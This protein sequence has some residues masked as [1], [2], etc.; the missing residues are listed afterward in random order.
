[1]SMDQAAGR[2]PV[3]VSTRPRRWVRPAWLCAAAVLIGLAARTSHYA[4]AQS[5]WYD[6]AFVLLNVFERSYLS[7]LGPLDHHLISPPGYLMLLRLLYTV[8]GGGERV[9]RLPSLV[10]GVIALGVM[11]PLGRR[12]AG[13]TGRF[14][15]V[16]LAALSYHVLAHSDDVHPYTFDLLVTELVLLCALQILRLGNSSRGATPGVA[17]LAALAL[18]GPWFSFPSVFTF[19]AASLTLVPRA[20]RVGWRGRAAWTGINGLLAISLLA[21]W[22]LCASHQQHYDGIV[23]HWGPNGWGGFPD[24]SRVS[25][26]VSWVLTRPVQAAGYATTGMGLVL[27]ILA[28]LGILCRAVHG[29]RSTSVLLWTPLGLALAAAL[30][31]RY[32]LADRTQMFLAPGIWLAAACGVEAVRRRLPVRWRPA[33]LA[34][35]AVVVAQELGRLGNCLAAR[36][37]MTP[38]RE[39]FAFVHRI[40]RPDDDVFAS[41][42][43]VHRVYYRANPPV[44]DVADISRSPEFGRRRMWVVCSFSPGRNGPSV[45]LVYERLTAAGSRPVERYTFRGLDVVLYEPV[46]GPPE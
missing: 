46:P 45:P 26:F 4:R 24:R 42:A 6:E 19:G 43:V 21:V 27:T 33:V 11:F 30:M 15:A 10:A 8:A 28:V 40:Q 23:E 3:A 31:N 5:Y 7:L 12:V 17:G 37:P 32:P 35:L 25:A 18:L 29:G 34:L 36:D 2:E 22:W 20:W 14:W 44:L 39:A 41:E 13:R 1:M 9:M 16:A 38:F